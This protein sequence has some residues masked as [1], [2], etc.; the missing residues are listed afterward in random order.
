LAERSKKKGAGKKRE[1]AFTKKGRRT[2]QI[3]GGKQRK[4]SRGRERE[5]REGEDDGVIPSARGKKKGRKKPPVSSAIT[6]LPT[7]TNRGG[8]ERRPWTGIAR[9]FREGGEGK[10]FGIGI[11]REGGKR[12]DTDT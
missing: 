1:T 12:R 3:G 5:K 9:V 6:Q 11:S 10:F 7:E 2:T 4:R 8:G